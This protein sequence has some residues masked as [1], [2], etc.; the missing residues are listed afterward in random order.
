MKVEDI[1]GIIPPM[2]TPMHEDE[3]ID[4][5]TLRSE[6]ERLIAGGVHGIFCL[7][8]NGECYILT[9]EEKLKVL[10]TVIDQVHGRMP[11]Y[12]GTG[13]IST[14]ETE[15]LSRQ[16]QELG[17]DALSIITPSFARASQKELYD[18]Y[19]NVAKKVDIP[20]ILYNIPARTGN[21]LL[22]ETVAR[23]ATDVDVIVG[24]KDSSGDWNNLQAYIQQTADLGNDF[25]VLSGN[26]AL[27][28]PCLK[29]GGAGGIAGCANVYPKLLVSIY[30][31]FMEGHMEEAQRAQDAIATFRKVFQYGNPNTIIKMAAALLGNP[32]GSCRKPFNHL[33]DEGVLALEAVLKENR[34]KG[35]A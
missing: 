16:A 8:T 34:S 13:C 25:R 10:E 21:A 32:V 18:H 15:I 27:I 30:N 33:C 29:I 23:L 9:H 2:L 20:I 35:L 1:K 31:Q 26:D 3:S 6:V 24:V 28:L 11:V 19:S 5:N 22:P 14:R 17:A 7:G 4:Y 12:A